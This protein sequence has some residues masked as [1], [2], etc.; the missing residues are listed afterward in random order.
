MPFLPYNVKVHQKGVYVQI[1]GL[2]KVAI[3]FFV[4]FFLRKNEYFL[5]VFNDTIFRLLFKVHQKGV[6]V[7]IVGLCKVAIIYF[8]VFFL[9]KN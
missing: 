1:V 3:I 7:Q 8:V 5:V 9:R 6:Y 4:V 2:C